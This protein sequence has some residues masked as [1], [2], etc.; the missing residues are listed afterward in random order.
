MKGGRAMKLSWK[1]ILIF[2]V[3]LLA[4]TLILVL[5][6]AQNILE[7]TN[8]YTSARFLNMGKSISKALD[9]QISMMEL[10]A[11]ELLDNTSFTAALNQMVRDDSEDQKLATAASQSVLQILYRSPLVSNH[12]RVTFYTRDGLFVTSHVQRGDVL[13]SGTASAQAVISALPWL[14]DVDADPTRQHILEPHPDFLAMQRGARVFGIVQ[15]VT[16]HDKQL[17]Y[18]EVCSEYTIL[19]DLMRMVDEDTIMTQAVFDDGTVLYSDSRLPFTCPEDLPTD[20]LSIYTDENSGMRCN[21]MHVRCE[22]LS[23]NIY[24]VQ[25]KAIIENSQALVRQEIMEISFIIMGCAIVLVVVVSFRLTRSIRQLTSKVSH[26]KVEHVLNNQPDVTQALTATV[27]AP[28]DAELHQLEKVFNDM[29]LHLRESAQNELILREGTLQAQLSALQTQINPHFIYNTLNI[30][31]AKSMENGNWEVIEICDQ[32]ARL[33]RYSTDT[34]SRAATLVEEIENVR[35]YLMLAKCRYEE[36]LE[37]TIDIPEDITDIRI[38]KLT[39]Q[40]LVENALNHGF[41]GNNDKRCLSITGKLEDNLLSL[42]I[43][44]NGAGFLPEILASLQQKLQQIQD[45]TMTINAAGG[46]IGL[47]NTCL[48]LHYYSQGT[49]RVSIR[50]DS[51]AVVCLTMPSLHHHA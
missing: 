11:E 50:N 46:H 4:T 20:T 9:Q 39:L 19:N 22:W 29:M 28:E 6:S 1:M 21:V 32:F 5:Y 2:S 14:D 51:G 31:S 10:T 37:F 7:S 49:M 42:E 24:L 25:D 12:Y 44:D 48:R 8:V 23:L 47:I 34:R 35:C 41:T 16:Y 26:L 15:A 36:N 43:R 18:L 3:M 45:G 33:L 13:Q 40:P 17:G 27:I 38:P 30:I